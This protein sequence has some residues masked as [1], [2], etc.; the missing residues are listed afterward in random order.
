MPPANSGEPVAPP[1]PHRCIEVLGGE[2]VFAEQLR[3]AAE[4][5][6]HLAGVGPVA[7]YQCGLAEDLVTAADGVAL[8]LLDEQDPGCGS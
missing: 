4:R 3:V 1:G 7:A 2:T 6:Q 8:H 5:F